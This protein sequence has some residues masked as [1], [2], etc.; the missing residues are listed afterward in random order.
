MC[1]SLLLIRKGGVGILLFAYALGIGLT[2]NVTI[3]YLM[4]AFACFLILERTHL[5]RR[6]LFPAVLLFLLGISLYLYIPIRARFHPVFNWGD[7]STLKNFI[8]LLTAQEFSKG[9]LNLSYAETG[10][11]SAFVNLLREVSFWGVI[12]L[13]YGIILLW[14]KE[15]NIALLFIVAIAGNML[16][17]F[18]TGRGPDFNA[19]FLP[20]I[21]IACLVIGYG[22][23][24]FISRMGSRSWCALPVLFLLCLSP[25]LLNHRANCRRHDHDARNYG[26]A[27]LS[28][29]PGDGIL[30]TENT[31]DYFILTYLEEIEKV[32][33]ASIFYAPLFKEAWYRKKLREEG[34]QWQEPLTPLSFAS[35]QRKVFYTPGA[36]IS[37]PVM[38]LSPRGPLFRIV[39]VEEPLQENLFVLPQ[40]VRKQGKRRYAYLF[41]RFGE[42]YFK[43]SHFRY[44]IAAFEQAKGYDPK[45][46]ALHHNLAL[47]YRKIGDHEKAREYDKTAQELGFRD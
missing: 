3:I 17:S 22:I 23:V 40:P 33:D 8:H 31:N 37:L 14:K 38:H 5:K 44:A 30:L 42:F 36:G 19:Y 29:L 11:T 12:P 24:H 7:A 20:S 47:L 6:Y 16:F 46:P 15:R 13:C 2:N 32:H 18:L 28:W 4:P 21:T 1:A 10:L 34:F 43:R 41:S 9:F 45:N 27:L 39:M 35:Q 26:A 25:I